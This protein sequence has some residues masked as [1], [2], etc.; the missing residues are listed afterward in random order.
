ALFSIIVV[1]MPLIGVWLSD[2][3]LSPF[4]AFPPLT[5]VALHRPFSWLFFMMYLA[6]ALGTVVL[7]ALAAARKPSGPTSGPGDVEHRF[8]WWGW[9]FL[10]LLG[11]F[12]IFAWTRFSWFVS[13]QRYTFIPLW[14]ASI[15]FL[16]G[17]CYRQNGRC[18]LLDETAFFAVLFPAS[19]LF[20]WSFEYL[21]QFTQNWYYT[22][23]NYGPTAYSIH[24]SISFST[25]LPAVYTGTVWI[26]QLR[27]V[28]RRFHPM[29]PLAQKLP[30]GADW[31]MLLLSCAALIGIALRPEELFALIWLAPLLLLT[32]LK[33]IAGRTTF[34]HYMAAGDWRPPV[35]AAMAA[36]LCG[37]FWEMW[38]YYS[39]AK[40]VYSI[41]FVYRFTLFEMP[42]LGY[43]GYLPFGLLCI[44]VVG[45]IRPPRGTS[46]ISG[47]VTGSDPRRFDRPPYLHDNGKRWG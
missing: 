22:G 39:L 40:W 38:N 9:V 34:L 19:A 47:S 12:W 17:L 8:P 36:L 31:M 45:L 21:N 44:E 26:S 23:V 16:N 1:G 43:L 7:L 25:V 3:P 6:A 28:R 11:V 18:P 46:E 15:G 24:A 13:L 4:A 20:W 5:A 10:V 30:K 2:R 27:W 42:A 33:R 37:F 29:P 41:P 35:A 32:A 14:L